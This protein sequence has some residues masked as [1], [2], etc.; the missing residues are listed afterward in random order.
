MDRLTFAL[1]AF[2]GFAQPYVAATSATTTGGNAMSIQWGSCEPFGYA[3][4]TLSCGLF[5]VP[6]DYHD[7]SAGNGRIAVIKANATGDR[8]GTFFFNPG[9]PGGSGLQ[10]LG[11][12]PDFVTTL[13]EFTGG[14][15]NVVS[16]DSRGV[17]AFSIPGEVYCFGSVDEYTAF[18]NGTIDLKGIEMYGNFTDETDLRDL[19]AQADTMEKRYQELGNMGPVDLSTTT[20]SRT[21]PSSASV[22][23]ERVGKVI[24]DGVLDPIA[25]DTTEIAIGWNNPALLDADRVYE[26]FITGC[27][28]AGSQGCAI[29]KEGQ[30]PLNVHASVQ[31]LLKAAHDADLQEP[32]VPYTSGLLRDGLY[33]QM[34]WPNSWRTL[35]NDNFIAVI[36]QEAQAVDNTTHPTLAGAMKMMKRHGLLKRAANESESETKSYTRSAIL[37]GDSIDSTGSLSM[38][39]LFDYVVES[40]RDISHMFGALWP[41]YTYYCNHWP[42]RAVETYRG[43]FDKTLADPILI[44]GNTY[45]PVTPF[46]SAKALAEGPGESA[47]LVRLNGVGHTTLPSPSTCIQNIVLAFRNLVS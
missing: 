44:I 2:A 19:Y 27:A 12:Y 42:A 43:P 9:G 40:S 20:V 33:E 23:P 38:T 25:L 32:T 1:A 29:T 3:N 35:S 36:T 7:P 21:A 17:G 41:F 37:C 22:F 39:D 16:W 45:D 14:T 34:Y 46:R 15:Y 18:F 28:L 47:G 26:A 5:E 4:S 24:I 30:T 8:Q 6:L 13:L 10:N 31:E 11:P